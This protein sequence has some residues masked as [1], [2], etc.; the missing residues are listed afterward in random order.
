MSEQDEFT[1][2]AFQNLRGKAETHQW[3][4]RPKES[5]R[6]EKEGRLTAVIEERTRT[7]WE[8]LKAARRSGM[9]LSEAKE[10]ALPMILLPEED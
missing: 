9:N 4:F 7:C 3:Q 8:S 2:P 1:S 5:E 6:L 10:V